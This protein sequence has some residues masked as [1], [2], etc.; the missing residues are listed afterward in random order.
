M[1]RGPLQG[2]AVQTAPGSAAARADAAATDPVTT[3]D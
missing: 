2:G 3:P 1:R